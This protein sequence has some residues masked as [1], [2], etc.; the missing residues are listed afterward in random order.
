MA[1]ITLFI[2]SLLLYIQDSRAQ[3]T[4][5]QTPAIST[6]PGGTVRISCKRSGS[7]SSDCGT[8][9]ISWYQQ[10]SGE[11]PKLLIYSV[12]SLQSGIPSR[13]SGSGSG[14]DYSLTISGVQSEDAG[15]FYCMSH[16]VPTGIT[17]Q[18]TQ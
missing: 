10:Q 11:K 15:D 8:P 18:F 5:T 2:Y 6:S 3:V 14:N 7:I 4:V 17:A 9:C 13:F 1:F 16:H 12:S